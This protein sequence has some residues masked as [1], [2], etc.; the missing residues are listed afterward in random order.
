MGHFPSLPLF[1]S[2]FRSS[3]YSEN[4][5]LA[6]GKMRLSLVLLVLGCFLLVGSGVMAR[7]TFFHGSIETSKVEVRENQ[8][9]GVVKGSD[10]ASKC[11]SKNQDLLCDFYFSHLDRIT[12]STLDEK[13][14]VPTGPNPLH[15]R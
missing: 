7:N 3:S 4:S 14:K 9:G 12:N 10:L 8:D 1:L 11:M 2:I 5:Q 15:N 6:E 13:R